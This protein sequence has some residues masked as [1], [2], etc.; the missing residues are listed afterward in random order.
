MLQPT[1]STHISPLSPDATRIHIR[2]WSQVE[3][4]SRLLS[5]QIPDFD[6]S[7]IHSEVCSEKETLHCNTAFSSHTKLSCWSNISKNT[8]V[9]LP[10]RGTASGIGIKAKQIVLVCGSDNV[11]MITLTNSFAICPVCLFVKMRLY[12]LPEDQHSQVWVRGLVHGFGLD[13]HAVLLRGQLVST[14]LLMPE[15]EKTRNRSPNHNQVTV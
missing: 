11:S 4:N 15:V 8:K 10:E 3:I 13:A 12:L 1:L 9:C 5:E 7:M 2:T 6:L 14:A